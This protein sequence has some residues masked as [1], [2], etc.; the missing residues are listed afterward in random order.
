M[1]ND[2]LLKY[3]M[4]NDL[5]NYLLRALNKVQIVGVNQA[6]DLITV[7]KLLQNPLNAEDLE[8]DQYE[9]LKSKFD[10][11]KEEKKK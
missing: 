11:P 9:S 2:K 5:V 1:G 6:N 10:K 3:E 4:T 7:T 8:K